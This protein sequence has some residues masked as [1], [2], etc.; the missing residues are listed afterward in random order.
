M[1]YKKDQ[2]A[3]DEGFDAQLDRVHAKADLKHIQLCQ[4]F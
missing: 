4:D 2:N 1:V 3:G